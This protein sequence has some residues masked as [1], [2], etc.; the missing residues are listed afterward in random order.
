LENAEEEIRRE[1]EFDHIVESKDKE[2]DYQK[3]RDFY[4]ELISF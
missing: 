4:K 3:V 1:G 2:S